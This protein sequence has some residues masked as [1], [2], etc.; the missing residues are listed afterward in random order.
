MTWSAAAG[1]RS[2]SA[3][4]D[5][6]TPPSSPEPADTWSRSSTPTPSTAASK[7]PLEREERAAHLHR[8]LSISQDRAGG[9]RLRGRGSAEDGALLMAA[10]L[11]LTCP[12][13]A[14]DR[15]RPATDPGTGEEHL[16]RRDHGARLWDA[17]IATAHHALDTGLP[18][19]THGTPARLLVTLDH[20]TS[21]ATSSAGTGTGVGT[22]ADGTELPPDTLRRLACDAEII[23]AVLGTHGE[24]LDVGRL[25]RLVTASH[26]DRP[27]RARPTLH[28][29]RLPT[30]TTDVPRPP[31]HPLGQPVAKRTSTTSPCLCGHHHRVIH[32]SPWE[33]RLN[34]TDRRPEFQT[35]THPRK[36][37]PRGSDIDLE[38][39]SPNDDARWRTSAGCP[40][41]QM[42]V[43]P[44]RPRPAVV[45]D[46]V[47]QLAEDRR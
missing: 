6:S 20:Q 18:P 38:W 45:G 21:R 32:H 15:A 43:D 36:P 44:L 9:V 28:L 35:T 30:A 19:E 8:Y 17:L 31:P 1:R 13:P 24:V 14:P 4:P 29:P 12:E 47:R 40:P 27:G 37:I 10:L 16:D 5:T 7:P 42:G 11:P 2:W 33:I 39:N 3:R 22:T 23:P 41:R 25:R 26:L 34:P 46:R